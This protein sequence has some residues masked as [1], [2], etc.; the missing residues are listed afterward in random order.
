MTEIRKG[1]P[2]DIPGIAAIYGRILTEEAG[3]ASVG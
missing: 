3:R 2:A 1:V